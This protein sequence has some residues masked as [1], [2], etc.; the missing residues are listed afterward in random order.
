[1]S[2]V[3]LD[4]NVFSYVLKKHA[5]ATLYDKHLDGKQQTLC[6]AVV[7]ELLQ[8]AKL[9]GWGPANVAKLEESIHTVTIIPYD[10]G[11]CRAWASLCDAKNPDGSSRTFENNDRWIAACA[12][13]HNIPLISHNRIHFEGIPGLHLISEAP[14]ATG[15]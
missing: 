9:R 4:T 3:L 1:M 15:P 8:G 10:I 2:A 7:A 13:H 11:V 6:F 14:P 5:L 12:L